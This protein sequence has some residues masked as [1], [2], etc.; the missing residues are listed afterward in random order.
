MI[1][2]SIIGALIF[3]AVLM[4]SLSS[5]K[6]ISQA[7]SQEAAPTMISGIFCDK[8]EQAETL[9]QLAEKGGSPQENMDKVNAIAKDP[10]ACGRSRV[11][12]VIGQKVGA[13]YHLGHGQAVQIF[14]VTVLAVEINGRLQKL[15]PP[16]TGYT[17]L[18]AQDNGA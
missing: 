14:A 5:C 10:N 15:T 1:S 3:W 6:W 12:V 2:K 9:M 17:F 11:A 16:Q 7:A 8:I 13:V 4:V 18:F